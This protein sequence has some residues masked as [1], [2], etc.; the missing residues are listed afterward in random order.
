MDEHEMHS[1]KKR[2]YSTLYITIFHFPTSKGATASSH[3]QNKHLK[4]HQDIIF[5]TKGSEEDHQ[6]SHIGTTKVK[7]FKE[8]TNVSCCKISMKT[9]KKNPVLETNYRYSRKKI[10]MS[11]HTKLIIH[12]SQDHT[13]LVRTLEKNILHLFMFNSLKK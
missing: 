1:Q 13:K 7:C 12:G 2:Q 11:L 5:G 6:R 10:L 4:Q 9:E 8:T 3:C